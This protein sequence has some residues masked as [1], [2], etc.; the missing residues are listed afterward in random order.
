MNKK[1]LTYILSGGLNTEDAQIKLEP[2][3]VRAGS[4]NYE[5][6][7][8]GGY[9]CVDG[10]ERFD[11]RAAPSAAAYTLLVFAAAG[12]TTAIAVGNTLTGLSSASSGTVVSVVLTGGSWAAGDATGEIA[13]IGE[14]ANS[15][16]V[17][18]VIQVG[19]VNRGTA[20]TSNTAQSVG[21]TNFKAHMRGAQAHYRNLIAAVPGSGSLIGIVN[22]ATAQNNVYAF[23]LNAGGTTIELYRNSASGWTKVVMICEIGFSLGT[24]ADIA[25]GTTLTQGANTAIIRGVTLVSGTFSGGDAL[26]I[27]YCDIP[28]PGAFAIGAATTPLGTL[29]LSNASS[30]RVDLANVSTYA[31]FIVKNFTG[32]ASKRRIYGALNG[33]AGG[34]EIHPPAS[35]TVDKL[36]PNTV[37]GMN[38]AVTHIAEHLG[39]LWFT[40]V[41]GSTQYS[42][43][44][45]PRSW[46]AVIGAGEL[47]LGEECTGIRSL[48]SDQLA[49]TGANTV[50]VLYGTSLGSSDFRQLLDSTGCTPHTLDEVNGAAIA[51]DR[52]GTYF[53][54]A[55]QEFGDF[56]KNALSRK[57]ER[58]I[59]KRTQDI[60]FALVCKN[61]SQYRI[62]FNDKTG[63]TATFD[64]TKLIGWFPFRLEHQFVCGWVGD[65]ENGDEVMYVGTDDGYVMQL[66]KGTSFDGE[67]I[68]HTLALAFTNMGAEN[69]YKR[70]YTVRPAVT[71]TGGAVEVSLYTQLDYG[72]VRGGVDDGTG[73]PA[74]GAVYGQSLYG[75][76]FYGAAVVG[77]SIYN[78]DG[79]GFN[80]SPVFIHEDD[81]DEPF[82]FEAN[83]IEYAPTKARK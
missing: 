44:N 5:C 30:Q 14:T 80:F 10:Y 68:P 64:G 22:I 12:N 49:I 9:R 62:F 45:L 43:A 11:G 21:D 66:D 33:F 28:A 36:V 57:V 42:A 55:S 39:R 48:K 35:P 1:P 25:E 46:S 23:R 75:A 27:L 17:A 56:K 24:N 2:G 15:F 31:E 50:R 32:D 38:K 83:T 52:I 16:T 59:A 53:L 54:Q 20:T 51:T 81:I 8:G 47:A 34:F 82:T 63:I 29:T 18:E 26:G 7:Q 71:S 77:D 41:G 76:T 70:Y 79:I 37:P 78:I 65:D 74:T 3:N 4:V 72:A 60:Q 40:F 58:V 13:L 6:V 67:V 19:G 69:I 61:K 73:V